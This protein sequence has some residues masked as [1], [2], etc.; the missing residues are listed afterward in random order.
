MDL[1]MD[2]DMRAV[3]HDRE[4]RDAEATYEGAV[5][6][7]AAMIDSHLEEGY[8]DKGSFVFD[9]MVLL[10]AIRHHKAMIDFVEASY[11]EG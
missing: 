1:C 11:D 3:R 4:L 8:S 7:L 10:N 9:A 2:E 5:N 6:A